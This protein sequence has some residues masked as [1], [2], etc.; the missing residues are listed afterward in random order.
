MPVANSATNISTTDI[1]KDRLLT[2]KLLKYR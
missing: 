2:G 1:E